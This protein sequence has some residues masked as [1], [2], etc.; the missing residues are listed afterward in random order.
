MPK[1][2]T[3]PTGWRVAAL[4]SALLASPALA[5][6]P[7]GPELADWLSRNTDLPAAQ[8][9]IVAPEDVYSL[10]PLGPRL[11]DGQVI[12]LVRTEVLAADWGAAHGFQSWEAHLM[13]DCKGG[14]VRILK[15]TVYPEPN[16][17]GAAKVESAGGDWFTPKSPE[18]AVRLLAAACDASFVWPLRSKLASTAPA[19]APE[20]APAKVVAEAP[21]AQPKA[22]TRPVLTASPATAPPAATPRAAPAGPYAIQ[23]VYTSS[24]A[25][26]RYSLAQARTTLGP[27]AT[28]LSDVMQ[29]SEFGRHKRPRLT[30]YLSG[31]AD[32]GSAQRACETLLK[33]KQDC[34]VRPALPEAA[35]SAGPS[36]VAAQPRAAA[37][38]VQVARGPSEAGAKKAL[39][40][41][42]ATLGPLAETLT[43][44]TDE[45]R[46]GRRRRY[47]ARLTGFA[48]AAAAGEACS[49]LVSA[50]QSCFARAEGA[51]P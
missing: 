6:A 19:K 1:A 23:I 21:A 51:Q 35:A 50:G 7:S 8:V 42:R 10:Q 34:V 25:G 18:P 28:G 17:Q 38:F 46:L 9:A 36:P 2:C 30:G 43:D 44:A 41:G 13:F 39:A 16:R 11:P 40:Q 45:A 33:A 27:V 32:A 20:A 29:S 3:F 48:T 14:R 15:S 12:A 49:K 47:T 37:F 31:F 4:A 24:E 26:A 5:A 22:E